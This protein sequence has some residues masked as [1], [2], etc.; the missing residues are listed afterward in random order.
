MPVGSVTRI[1]MLLDSYSSYALLFHQRKLVPYYFL[2]THRRTNISTGVRV[3]RV[4]HSLIQNF[5]VVLTVRSKMVGGLE[6]L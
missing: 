5:G 2:Q 6:G 4:S 3:D 1:V